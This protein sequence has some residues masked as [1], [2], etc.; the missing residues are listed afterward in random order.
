MWL[1]YIN[2]SI[3]MGQ[4]LNN[5]DRISSTSTT[6]PLPWNS[7]LSLN[8]AGVSYLFLLTTPFGNIIDHLFIFLF[9]FAQQRP[10]LRFDILLFPD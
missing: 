2:K 10:D 3:L 8:P 4:Q 7:D 9:S 5:Q 6:V 1:F